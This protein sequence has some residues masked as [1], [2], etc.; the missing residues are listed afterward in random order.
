MASRRSLS[1]MLAAALCGGPLAAAAGPEPVDFE[2]AGGGRFVRLSALPPQTTLVNF[3][4]S[5]CPPCVREL[6]LLA[7]LARSGEI[8][9]ITV[10]LQRP[11]ES[12]SAPAA[13]LEAL[14][15]PIL[16]LHGPSDPRG[17]LARFGNPRGAL[18][19]TVLLDPA[20]R[21]CGQRTGEL[22][23]AWLADA[24]ARCPAH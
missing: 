24:Q 1:V 21:P 13:I 18:P 5:D 2:L 8:R 7:E 22:S 19:H 9:V 12:A 6:P 15:E 3:W 11:W 14:K 16:A 4:R 17:L 23:P 20:R 10:A